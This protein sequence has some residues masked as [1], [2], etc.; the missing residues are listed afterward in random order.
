MKHIP[1]KPLSRP[2]GRA[3][4]QAMSLIVKPTERCNFKC[5]FCSS[6][7]LTDTPSALLDIERIKLFL[8]R[9]PQTHTVIING[10][11]PLMVP[12]R[13]YWGLIEYIE[14]NR[15]PTRLSFTTNLWA[16]YKNPDKWTPLFRHERVGVSTS[17][18]YGDTRRVTETQ[19]FTEADFVA[20]SDLMLERVGYR[21]D[22]IAV[23][24][25][26][27][28]DTAID[29]VRLAK[30]L[31]VECKLNYAMASGLQSTPFVPAMLYQVYVELYKLDLWQWEHNTRAM[32]KRLYGG[33]EM[34]PQARECQTSIRCLQP[35]GDYYS[36]GSFGDDKAY[37]IDFD[38][39]IYGDQQIDPFKAATELKALHK[40]CYGCELF[41]ICNGCKK[42]IH[43]LKQHGL[44][45][46]HCRL[47]TELKDEIVRI[48][49]ENQQTTIDFHIRKG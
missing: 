27:T 18:N 15:L 20:I 3:S 25:E 33:L 8:Q 45:D 4:H 42:T 9:Y 2:V 43:D 35:D 39:E 6:T 11:D 21:P 34:C 46:E 26:A 29:C 17:F 24:N 38:L 49:I 19:V 5:T 37:P 14:A 31:D 22:F 48:N 1:I 41:S 32:L 36:C 28:I 7:E 23:I 16:F 10:G 40:R 13:Y 12:I 44:A 30:R 47:M